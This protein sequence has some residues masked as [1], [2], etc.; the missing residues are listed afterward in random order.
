MKT[1]VLYFPYISIPKSQWL[2]QMLLYWDRVAS[3]VPYDFIQRPE[4][5]QPYMRALVQEDLVRQ[6]IPAQYTYSIPSF[7]SAFVAYLDGLTDGDARRGRCATGSVT[8]VHVEKMN[9]IGDALVSRGLATRQRYPWYDVERDT[10]DDFMSYLACALGQLDPVDACPMTD[11]VSYLRR[12]C[13]SGVPTADVDAQ[14]AALR[15]EVLEAI[16]PVPS[17]EVAPLEIRSFK[18]RHGPALS[19]FRRR[20]ERELI[21]AAAL[22]DPALRSRQLGLFQQEAEDEI[23]RIQSLT[24]GRGWQMARAAVSVVGAVPG[25]SQLFGLAAAVW[26]AVGGREG[27]SPSREF[28]YAACARSAF[29]DGVYHGLQPTA[30]GAGRRRRG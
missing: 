13:R 19:D 22:S 27:A 21:A 12:F 16:L 17:T 20:V 18:D 23:L 8:P 1:Q 4:L 25:V 11:Q 5:L 9:D 30:P 2:T 29:D 10:A 6:V 24:A 3:I 26:E 14:L 15:I 7:D 28:A